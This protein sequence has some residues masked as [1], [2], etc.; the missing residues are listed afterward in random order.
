MEEV[1]TYGAAIN[2]FSL[3]LGIYVLA[4]IFAITMYVLQSD[5]QVFGAQKED[6]DELIN[7]AREVE[8]VRSRHRAPWRHARFASEPDAAPA[9]DASRRRAL[10][11]HEHGERRRASVRPVSSRWAWGG[12][13][14]GWRRGG[15]CVLRW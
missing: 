13:C 3:F 12:C 5:Y 10:H 6:C 2:I 11:A 14:S 8:G 9:R 4:I 7:Y 15:R 1:Y